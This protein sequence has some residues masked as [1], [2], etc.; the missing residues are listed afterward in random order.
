V[1]EADAGFVTRVLD[2]TAGIVSGSASYALTASGYLVD[3][4]AYLLV[5]AVSGSVI[6]ALP[7]LEVARLEEKY[8]DNGQVSG[9]GGLV[10]FQELIKRMDPKKYVPGLGA[11]AFQ[12]TASWRCQL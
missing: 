10:C 3:G 2:S 1:R 5:P 6:C 11:K 7:A 12:A 8:W 4:A 9:L